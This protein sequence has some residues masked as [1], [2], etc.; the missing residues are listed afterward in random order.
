MKSLLHI[1]AICCLAFIPITGYS[2]GYGFI[3]EENPNI[4]L[5]KIYNGDT[6]R[7]PEMF[8]TIIAING[9]TIHAFENNVSSSAIKYIRIMLPEKSRITIELYDVNGHFIK[10]FIR[11]EY[12]KGCY[13]FEWNDN[14]NHSDI[15][16]GIYFL[17]FKVNNLEHTRMIIGL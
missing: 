17:I 2:T 7:R 16:P 3:P 14:F 13:E 8:S 6:A 4:V 12:E 9:A 10:T 5:R 15:A 1:I 11:G